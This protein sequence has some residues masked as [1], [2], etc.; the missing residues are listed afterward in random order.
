MTTADMVQRK[1][2]ERDWT[3]Y[4]LAQVAGLPVQ[5][6]ANVLQG[7]GVYT[8]TLAKIAAAL[9]V[10]IADLVPVAELEPVE[11]RGRGR[12]KKDTGVT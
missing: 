1:L 12:P 9:E 5:T 3:A 4:R 10:S 2:D 7:K 8:S 11:M 6:V